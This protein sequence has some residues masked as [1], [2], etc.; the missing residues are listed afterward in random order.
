[1]RK[2]FNADCTSLG[3]VLGQ[4]AEGR[5]AADTG[6]CRA[7]RKWSIQCKLCDIPKAPALLW[8]SVKTCW[9]YIWPLDLWLP[10][11]W[12]GSVW[13]LLFQQLVKPSAFTGRHLWPFCW[14]NIPENVTPEAPESKDKRRFHLFLLTP[15]SISHEFLPGLSMVIQDSV[16]P[17]QCRRSG[18]SLPGGSRAQRLF[19]PRRRGLS[20]QQPNF[21]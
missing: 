18:S 3:N 12:S 16:L 19:S 6:R 2:W 10:L 5:G 8:C 20:L 4:S 7:V 14:E 11:I 13:E 15:L 17:S 9:L 1:M 21:K